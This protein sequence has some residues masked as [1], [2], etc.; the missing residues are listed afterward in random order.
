MD[1]SIQVSLESNHFTNEPNA[2]K[3]LQLLSL[4]PDG[5]AENDL[6]QMAGDDLNCFRGSLS[7]RPGH[8]LVEEEALQLTGGVSLDP[9]ASQGYQV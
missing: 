2:L 3:L 4:L 5:V 6:S 1:V 8:Q 9:M 7:D